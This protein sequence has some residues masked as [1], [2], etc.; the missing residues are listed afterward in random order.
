MSILS[1]RIAVDPGKSKVSEFD[2]ESVSVD[3]DVL[4]F[5]V[6]MHDSVRMAVL[7]RQKKLVYNSLD[8]IFVDHNAF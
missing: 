7:K 2:I 3:K 6:A 1:Q 8:L 4:R 5:E